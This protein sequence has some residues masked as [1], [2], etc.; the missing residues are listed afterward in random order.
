MFCLKIL[1]YLLNFLDNGINIITIET[2]TENIL[3]QFL[4]LEA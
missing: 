3:K 2:F 1:Y 4:V